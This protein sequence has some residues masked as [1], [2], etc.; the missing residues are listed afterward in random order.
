[1]NKIHSSPPFPTAPRS[2][3][4]PPGEQLRDLVETSLSGPQQSSMIAHLDQCDDC[5]TRLEA[6]AADGEQ[7]RA[8]R[9]NLRASDDAQ[10]LPSARLTAAIRSLQEPTREDLA[11]APTGL[12]RAA[13][14]GAGELPQRIGP[15]EII[16]LVGRGGMGI[17]YKAFDPA[18]GR[19]VAIKVM[20]DSFA[21]SREALQRIRRE[22]GS[23]AAIRDPHVVAIYAIEDSAPRPYLVME[24]VEGMPLEERLNREGRLEWSEV[25][26]IGAEAASGLAAAHAAGLIHRD[27]KP[28]NI[29]IEQ[30]TGCVKIS[31]FGLARAVE[32]SSLT[33]T[34]CVRGTPEY[35]SPEQAAGE[36]LDHRADL[37]SLGSVLYAACT[38]LPPF[39]ADNT[40]AVLQRTRQESPAPID[41]IRDDVPAA[42]IGVINRLLSK[43]PEDR[44]NSAGEVAE[45]LRRI[46]R[47][48]AVALTDGAGIPRSA[49][50][51]GPAWKRVALAAGLLLA[52]GAAV[53]GIYGVASSIPESRE[54]VSPPAPANSMRAG[55]PPLA[56]SNPAGSSEGAAPAELA[57]A[58]AADG[59]KQQPKAPPVPQPAE[60]TKPAGMSV[61]PPP[62]RVQIVTPDGLMR[63]RIQAEKDL[64]ELRRHPLLVREFPGHTGPVSSLAFTPDGTWVISGSGWPT[65]DR[66][67]RVWEVA[68]GKEV[69]RFD[70]AAMPK[71]PGT[72]GGREAPGE[73]YTVAV[74]PDGV[75]A[76]TGATG[77]AVGVWEIATGKLV[78]QFD[79]HTA[80]VFGA[81]VSPKGDVV[82][83]GGRDSIGR[84]WNL[85]TGDELLQ[86]S[87]HRSWV[88]SVAVSPDGKRALTGSYDQV[89]RLWDLDK[90]EML[91]EFKGDG[92][93]WDLAFAPSGKLAVA[94]VGNH[95]HLWDLDSGELVRSLSGHG[96]GTTAV[97]VSRDGRWVVSGGYDNM[98]RL[99]NVDTGE[100]L[101]TYTGH[102]DWV[103]DVKFAP[104]GR[105][106]A[107]AGGGRYTA[108]GGTEAGIDFTLRLWKLPPTGPRVAKPE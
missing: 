30:R 72:S 36:R 15:Y 20:A 66:T 32:D 104:D 7:W 13:A 70:T 44:F 95:V 73:V 99:W 54:T 35:I 29:L 43:D 40:L 103:F 81:A 79:K 77:G 57:V 19:H 56:S 107:S 78:R 39:Q 28:A 62:A 24:F 33:Q 64:L 50:P 21:A 98:V 60:A 4:C 1:M 65:G 105:H 97:D 106:V 93:V 37:F 61:P 22:A 14:D 3:D 2:P 45:L 38:G 96:G 48:E 34:G 31:D 17:V 59:E 101:E 90:A 69:R 8:I 75:H 80:T 5:R 58:L 52:V 23:E 53:A 76:V 100:L 89:M 86:L 83:S 10:I 92:W 55:H 71:N 18:L 67:V 87:G 102:R 46:Q 88:R 11:D 51:R 26:R 74:T 108:T 6:I 16:A 25:A 49:P 68:T 9:H 94:A 85:A 47:G 12:D 41:E 82:L 42:L 63:E 91:H 27:I 84:L